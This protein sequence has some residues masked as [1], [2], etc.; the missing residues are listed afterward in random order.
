[1]GAGNLCVSMNE[2]SVGT[3]IFSYFLNKFSF[4]FPIC[5]A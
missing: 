2:T 3:P 5:F 4:F 1:M